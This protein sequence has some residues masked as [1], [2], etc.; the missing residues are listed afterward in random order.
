MAC[1]STSAT[2]PPDRVLVTGISGFLGCHVAAALANAGYA[3][4]GTVRDHKWDEAII[5]AV[6]A[7]VD[8]VVVDLAAGTPEEWMAAVRGCTMVCHVASPFYMAEPK[9]PNDLIVPAV[10]GTTKV[11]RACHAAGVKRVAL[12]SSTA[13]VSIGH[14]RN[15][16]LFTENDW[17]DVEKAGTYA[18]SKTLAER[19]AWDCAQELGLEL[20]VLNPSGIFG[21]PLL[22][23]VGESGD[24]VKK[25]VQGDMPGTF[26]ISLPMIDVRDV[27]LAHV[28]ALQVPQAAGKRYIIHA[29]SRWMQEV[30]TW[31]AEGMPEFKPKTKPVPYAVLWLFA[32][33]NKQAAGV[34]GGWKVMRDYD[35][36]AAKQDLG[37]TE[38]RKMDASVVD[39]AKAMDQHGLLDASKKRRPTP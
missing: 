32:L 23:R 29:E 16:E 10:E 28:R 3:V 5:R 36:T 34:K 13:A 37:F 19:A 38:W 11:L 27:A 4:R 7:S 31:L 24:A 8:F 6:G 30:V 14:S 20:V 26:A 39:M 18:K 2:A 25:M 9:D 15:D 12:T 22:P 17:S 33:V 1:T 35:T 21:P